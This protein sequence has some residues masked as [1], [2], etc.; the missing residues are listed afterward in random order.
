MH[1]NA[2]LYKY[3]ITC[4]RDSPRHLRRIFSLPPE[5]RFTT[6]HTSREYIYL[7]ICLYNCTSLTSALHL[8]PFQNTDVRTHSYLSLVAVYATLAFQPDVSGELV[9]LATL[10]EVS[11]AADWRMAPMFILGMP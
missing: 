6:L 2:G 1:S 9:C 4:L 5:T 3:L 11:I 10:M 8:K 7:P